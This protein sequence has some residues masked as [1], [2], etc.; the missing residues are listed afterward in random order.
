[1]FQPALEQGRDKWAGAIWAVGVVGAS[2]STG[3]GRSE[4][5]HRPRRGSVTRSA[6][7]LHLAEDE[8]KR[9][10]ETDK[11][12][13]VWAR[14]PRLAGTEELTIVAPSQVRMRIVWFR[15]AP[16]D[17]PDSRLR[18]PRRAGRMAI[19]PCRRSCTPVAP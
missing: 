9:I 4:A 10:F 1:M 16:G 2:A 8:S 6:T 15:G 12:R 14:G 11:V 3:F 19:F 18:F 13:V 17:R 7:D 5:A